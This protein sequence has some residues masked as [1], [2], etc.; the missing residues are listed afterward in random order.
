M[1]KCCLML[2]LA[3]F[4]QVSWAMMEEVKQKE[5]VGFS[6]LLEAVRKWDFE[7]AAQ[8]VDNEDVSA[9]GASDISKDLAKHMTKKGS[10]KSKSISLKELAL[11]TIVY[12]DFDDK[13]AIGEMIVNKK[14]VG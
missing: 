11:L 2:V 12:W 7:T 6:A 10:Y 9:V 3:L 1:K 13:F 8:L 4:H 5:G 14:I